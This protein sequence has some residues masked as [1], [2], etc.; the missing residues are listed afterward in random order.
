[1]L[2]NVEDADGNIYYQPATTVIKNDEKNL[3]MTHNAKTENVDLRIPHDTVVHVENGHGLQ[4]NEWADFFN[5]ISTPTDI[6]ISNK[7]RYD[8]SPLLL[9]YNINGK[10]YGAVI[11]FFENKKPILTTVFSDTEKKVSDWIKENSHSQAKNTSSVTAK[12]MLLSND[13]NSILSYFKNKLNPSEQTKIL[14]Q[15]ATTVIKNDAKIF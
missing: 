14:F 6:A 12:G 1:M 15:P 5:N 8:G 2:S 7:P 4:L 13:Y 10:T 9:K 3:L 11:E